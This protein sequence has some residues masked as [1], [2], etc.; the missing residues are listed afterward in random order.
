VLTAARHEGR[1]SFELSELF[2]DFPVAV[3]VRENDKRAEPAL[4][5]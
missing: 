5:P 2:A 4:E 3:L 1:G